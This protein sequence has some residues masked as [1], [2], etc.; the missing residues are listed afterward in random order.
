MGPGVTLRVA[1]VSDT[2][3]R[4]DPRIA[5]LVA[6]CDLAVHAGDIG[7]AAV[8]AGLAPRDGRVLAV[9]GNND[10]PGKWPEEDRQLL[11][12]LPAELDLHLPGGTLTL[13]HGHQAPARRRHAWLR[14]RFPASRAVVYGHS[15]RLAID[16][17]AWPWILNPG[18]AGRA[19]TYGGPSCLVL[20]AAKA[21]WVV[22]EHRFRLPERP[23]KG[24]LS[25]QQR[26]VL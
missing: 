8:L 1:I 25:G 11:A 23:R 7:S 17:D 5:S 10:L 16:Q 26:I 4:L 22:D 15:H 18:A 9:T 13:I 20:A 2:H 19:R 21:G 14:S 6:E 24:S 3:G 12:G